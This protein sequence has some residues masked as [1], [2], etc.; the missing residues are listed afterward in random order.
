[1][2][3]QRRAGGGVDQLPS[4]RYRVRIVTTDGR[5]VSL[6]T[7]ATKRAAEACYARTLTEQSDGKVVAPRRRGATLEEYTPRWVETRLTS[8]GGRCVSECATSN[9]GSRRPSRANDDSPHSDHRSD[10]PTS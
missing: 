2:A 6:G 3:R 8:K 7:F 5:R 1:M 10:S 9:G 4:G